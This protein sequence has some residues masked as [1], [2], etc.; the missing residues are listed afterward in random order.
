MNAAKIGKNGMVNL[1]AKIRERLGVEPGD[2]IAF[3]ERHGQIIVVPIRGA[4]QIASE[5]HYEKVVELIEEMDEEYYNE[6]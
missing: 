3:I 1:P 4:L 5:E 2:K 6:E